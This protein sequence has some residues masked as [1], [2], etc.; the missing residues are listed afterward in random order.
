MTDW[1]LG[2]AVGVDAVG[3]AEAAVVGAV[4]PWAVVVGDAVAV[5]VAATVETVAGAHERSKPWWLLLLRLLR[6]DPDRQSLAPPWPA[7]VAV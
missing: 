5:V 7:G 2:F 1:S 3:V 4:V 6:L